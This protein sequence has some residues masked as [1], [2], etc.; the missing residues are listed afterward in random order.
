MASEKVGASR[1]P[2]LRRQRSPGFIHRISTRRTTYCKSSRCG[3]L[4]TARAIRSG[5]TAYNRLFRKSFALWKVSWRTR[6]MNF[7]VGPLSSCGVNWPSE[8]HPTSGARALSNRISGGDS[9]SLMQCAWPRSLLREQS[10]SL[11]ASAATNRRL[12]RPGNVLLA[13]SPQRIRETASANAVAAHPDFS[14]DA[15]T[16]STARRIHN[17]LH[18][19]IMNA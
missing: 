1:S 18:N 10:E 7:V 9:T 11:T 19:H 2:Q 14:T 3:V 16:S 12:I 17:R 6:S 13:F 15:I 5:R 4:W 8:G